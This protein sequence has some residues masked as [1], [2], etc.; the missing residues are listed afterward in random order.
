MPGFPAVRFFFAAV[1]RRIF[2]SG[3]LQAFG[4]PGRFVREHG[5][6][7]MIRLQQQHHPAF[8]I[9]SHPDPVGIRFSGNFPGNC[10]VR[11]QGN[12]L[13][14]RYCG[15][16]FLSDRFLQVGRRCRGVFLSERS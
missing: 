10:L 14:S 7:R 6:N 8:F 3:L 5:L 16:R 13:I 15:L 9:Y 2:R 12:L 4:F 1:C 11:F